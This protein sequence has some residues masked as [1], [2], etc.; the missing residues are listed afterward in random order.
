MNNATMLYKCPGPHQIH[1]GNFDYI[2][3]GEDEIE[4]A[5]VD[6]WVLTTPEALAARDAVPSDGA[7]VS[8]DELKRKAAEMGLT[9]AGNV[10]NVKLA[11]LIEQALAAKA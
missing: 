2:I 10:S 11:E 4:Q 8:R 3:V 6:G 9:F 1:G 5:L 7:P